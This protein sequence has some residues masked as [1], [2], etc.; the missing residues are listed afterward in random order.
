MEELEGLDMEKEE[1]ESMNAGGIN[2]S[3]MESAT[4][5]RKGKSVEE[6]VIASS[7]IGMV[8]LRASHHSLVEGS[9]QVKRVGLGVTENPNRQGI[10]KRMRE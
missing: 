8:F 1:E 2:D 10:Q 6:T 7:L 3:C 4:L 5:A 9:K